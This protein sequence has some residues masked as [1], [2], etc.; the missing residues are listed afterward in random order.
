MAFKK[1]TYGK[2]EQQE[3]KG[4]IFIR[5]NQYKQEGDRSPDYRGNIQIPVEMLNQ[6]T[7]EHITEFRGQQYV[8]L[9]FGI[10]EGDSEDYSM[11]NVSFPR[12]RED[13]GKQRK[14]NPKTNGRQLPF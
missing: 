11:G 5:P 3:V 12:P 8:N 4:K 14:F 9:E 6:I 1:T 13:G 10:W 2:Q 7:E